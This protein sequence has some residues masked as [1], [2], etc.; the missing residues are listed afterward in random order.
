MHWGRR[1]GGPR[2]TY[3]LARALL[4]I[5]S[6]ETHLS[7]SRQSELYAQ[8]RGLGLPAFDIDTYA[9]VTSFAVGSLRVHSI[10]RKVAGYA[11]RE[12]I[13]VVLS[14]MHHLWSPFVLGEIRA[15]GPRIVSIVHDAQPH[16]GDWFPGWTWSLRR[17]IAASDALITLSQHVADL[18]RT[19]F[20]IS[21][22]R[23][24]RL[25]HPAFSFEHGPAKAHVPPAGRP[26][27]LLFLGRIKPYKGLFLFLDAACRIQAK[28]PIKAVIAGEGDLAPYET[29]LRRI[30]RLE[31]INHWIPEADIAAVLA[32]ADLV[33]ASHLEAS[34]SGIVPMAYGAGV[35][36]VATPVGG[37]REQVRPGV[38]GLLADR[39]SAQSL[40]DAIERLLGDAALYAQC[41]KGAAALGQDE[42]SWQRFA[43]ALVR[44]LETVCERPSLERRPRPRVPMPQDES[45]PS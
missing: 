17:E 30:E 33:V 45:V 10:A 20:G 24:H 3:E 38:T 19:K 40:A 11:S 23:V 21:A 12:K 16:S 32:R 5:Q 15:A 37:I 31:V 28:R 14:T 26:P 7:L 35:P 4:P 29:A 41:A 9:G 34:Q 42:L 27:C 25:P 39:V 8:S 22:D 1:G 13:D 2:F 36:V 44:I 18:L 43:P 6:L